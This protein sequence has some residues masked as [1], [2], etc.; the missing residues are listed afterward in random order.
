MCKFRGDL[1]YRSPSVKIRQTPVTTIENENV[2]ITHKDVDVDQGLWMAL[3]LKSVKV[4]VR[5]LDFCAQVTIAQTF[6]NTEECPIEAVYQF[7]LDGD[8]TVCNFEALVDGRKVVGECK[9]IDEAK[10]FYDDAV[11]GGA[12]N[13]SW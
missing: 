5:V 2:T 4:S 12:L 13:R 7:P 9:E 6:I 10:D 1:R 11:A 8:L 3:P